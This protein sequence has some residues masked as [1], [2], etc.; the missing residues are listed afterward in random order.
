MASLLSESIKQKARNILINLH[1]TW[2]RDI[3][4][5]KEPTRTVIATTPEYISIYQ[6]AQPT[7]IA[8][9]DYAPVSGTCKARIY[10]EPLFRTNQSVVAI[11]ND[12]PAK[13]D[14]G[15][16]RIKVDATGYALLQDSKKIT[17]DGTDCNVS[18]I[19]VRDG[20]FYPTYHTL[21]LT[22]IN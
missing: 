20:M 3:T 13:I 18:S 8:N 15:Y 14:K 6:D 12:I 19:N 10:Y 9:I 4:V 21:W 1:D 7:E 17:I 2:A 11:Q 16:I 5:W 22:R